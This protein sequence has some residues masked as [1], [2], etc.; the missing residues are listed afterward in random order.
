[1]ETGTGSTPLGEHESGLCTG[2]LRNGGE[3]R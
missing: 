2:G 1:M 3:D